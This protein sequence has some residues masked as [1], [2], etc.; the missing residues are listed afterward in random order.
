[1]LNSRVIGRLILIDECS[2]DTESHQQRPACRINAPRRLRFASQPR[3]NAIDP[4]RVL[5]WHHSTFC[6]QG[7]Q[8]AMSPNA[9]AMD[10]KT[11]RLVARPSQWRSD[12]A[13]Q[14]A[15]AARGR[16]AERSRA[17]AKCAAR[18]TMVAS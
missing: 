1:M 10:L 6:S 18:G 9:A 13:A 3:S 11:L 15:L 7:F 12:R 17:V 16:T 2:A 14:T 8:Y 4:M 5:T